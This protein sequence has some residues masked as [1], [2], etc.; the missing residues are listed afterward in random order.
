M[1]H[2][3]NYSGGLASW[4]EAY[5]TIAMHGISNTV[6]VFA[7]TK[8]EDADLYR[9]LEQTVQDFGC[10]FVKLADGRNIWELFKEEKFLGNSRTTPCSRILKQDVIS[11]WCAECQ[12]PYTEHFG[13]YWDETHR[14]ARLMAARDTPVFSILHSSRMVQ[15]DLI[16]LLSAKG[17]EIP[18]LYKMGLTHNNCGGG[19]VKAGKAHWTQ[20][21]EVFPERFA[22]WELNERQIQ[23]HIGKPVTMLKNGLSLENLRKAIQSQN[24]MFAQCDDDLGTSCGCLEEVS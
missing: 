19:C 11:K 5:L 8:A 9:F 20:L 23:E 1:T 12:M 18:R 13:F 2:I 4:G 15:S 21:L 10:K 6:L 14:L 16:D 24:S 7:D 17:I 3:V 22:E